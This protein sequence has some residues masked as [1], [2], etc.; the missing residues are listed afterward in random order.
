MA[1]Y[2]KNW[3]V[4]VVCIL[5]AVMIMTGQPAEVQAAKKNKFTYTYGVFLN[6]GRKEI[7]KFK[8]Y[9]TIVIDAQFFS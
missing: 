5:T 4:K 6:A 7:N 1:G 3:T 8:K 2:T 9:K